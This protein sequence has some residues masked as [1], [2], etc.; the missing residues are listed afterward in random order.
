M[1]SHILIAPLLFVYLNIVGCDNQERNNVQ[2]QVSPDS[3][4][5]DDD[6]Y[7]LLISLD[8][9]RYDY[10][11]K[12]GAEVILSY[13][14][15]GVK[16][17]KMYACYPT[18]T[19]PNHISIITG[20][21]PQSHGIVANEFYNPALDADY[22]IRDP[23]TIKD[24]SWYG[25]TPLWVLAEQQGIKTASYFWLGS[26]AAIQGVRPT[27]YEVFDGSVPYAERVDGVVDWFTLEKSKR[28]RFVTLY[29]P[30]A[31]QS[32]H[33]YGPESEQM[34]A[35]VKN[36]DDTISYLMDKLNSIELNINV[37]IVSD[38]GMIEIDQ[39]NKVD[40][41]V[42]Y[43][44]FNAVL[45]RSF[46]F[47]YHNDQVMLDQAYEILKSQETE[48]HYKVYWR[49]ETP[50]HLN[51][52]KNARAG[53]IIV[54]MDAPYI[55]NDSRTPNIG[56]HGYDPSVTPEMGAIFYAWGPQ[57]KIGMT[58]APFENVH[59]YPLIAQMLGLEYDQEGID[60]RLEV[61]EGILND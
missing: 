11:E 40:L 3:T 33:K 47:L 50:T 37:F 53:E 61:L 43:D 22:S 20:L 2:N 52:R 17:E 27:Y 10:A 8:G 48:K 7:V 58:I 55:I 57:I 46:A 34:E 18:K 41:P 12:Y 15:S 56:E 19:F 42:S 38:H 30:A 59:I 45:A 1:K 6:T 35:T 25:G 51:F 21:Y 49:G 60:G 54:I 44:E 5:A 39:D 28:P 36:L 24:G 23:Y 31:D 26:E 29:L 9:Y 14:N 4:I 13:A 32:G 16:A